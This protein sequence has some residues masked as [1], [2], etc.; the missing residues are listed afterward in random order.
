M[1]VREADGTVRQLRAKNIMVA[2]GGHAVKIDI[3]GAE[4]A[5]TSDEALVLDT[6]QPGLPIAVVG[7]GY[8]GVEFCGIFNGL[9]ANVHLICRQKYP[10][11]VFDGE[12][13]AVVSANMEGR[14]IKLHMEC[15]PVRVE[16]KPN[17]S[18]SV[19]FKN[20]HGGL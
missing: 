4:H 11:G 20:K 6:F 10:L 1:E 3:P 5:I 2:T 9:G 16:R 12:C 15:S 8:I 13:R 17:G 14:G 18:L 7:G 19:H